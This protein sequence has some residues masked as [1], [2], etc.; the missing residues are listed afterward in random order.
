MGAVHVDL[1]LHFPL[2]E[3]EVCD[4][5]RPLLCAASI[6]GVLPAARRIARPPLIQRKAPPERGIQDW[7]CGNGKAAHE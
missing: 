7:A 5:W 1:R 6:S 3:S 4:G 2:P